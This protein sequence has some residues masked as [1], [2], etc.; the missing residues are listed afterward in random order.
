MLKMSNTSEEA[1]KII[2]DGQSSEDPIKW[3]TYNLS[4]DSFRIM[5]NKKSSNINRLFNSI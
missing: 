2:V 5:F 3:E 1:I 4:F